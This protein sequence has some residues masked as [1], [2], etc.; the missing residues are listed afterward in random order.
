[1]TWYNN[2]THNGI[3]ALRYEISVY[4]VERYSFYFSFAS[5][6]RH[7]EHIKNIQKI[8]KVGRVP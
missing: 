4:C 3:L 6:R 1:M 8:R 5:P 2:G 7:E